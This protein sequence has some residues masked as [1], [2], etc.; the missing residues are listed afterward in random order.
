MEKGN[1]WLGTFYALAIIIVVGSG[2]LIEVSLR[3]N[4]GF[5]H[6]E[7]FNAYFDGSSVNHRTHTPN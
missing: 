6:R 3:R 7:V 1:V 2:L 4:P 5:A